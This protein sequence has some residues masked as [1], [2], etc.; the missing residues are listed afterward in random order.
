MKRFVSAMVAVA[1][2]TLLASCG[3]NPLRW[4]LDHGGL[5]ADRMVEI[6]DAINNQDAAALKEQFTDYARAEY[7]AEIDED[8]QYLLSLFPDGDLVWE[9]NGYRPSYSQ[10]YRDGKATYVVRAPFRVSYE[11]KD[12]WLSFALFTVNEIDPDNVGIYKLG[13]TPRTERRDSGPEEMFFEWMGTV[14]RPEDNPPPPPG[15]YVPHYDNIDLSEKAIEEVITDDLNIQ[16][17]L[18]LRERFTNYAQAQF[19]EALDDEIDALYDV[20]PVGDIAWEP[21]TREPDVRVEVDG[22]EETI[23]LLPVYRITAGGQVFWLF[24]AYYTVN[25]IDPDNLGLYGIGVAP[26]TATGDSAAE[27]ALFNLVD[28]FEIDTEI[29]PQ[30]VVFA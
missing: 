24:V 11:G 6:V 9:D 13:A 7:S 10:E 8:L 16:D 3:L 30:V 14:P 5:A 19:P 21:L 1:T 12:Y 4:M 2:V 29:P 22:E 15:V 17:S 26:R 18:G 27:Q 20:L 23:L 28:S 25:T